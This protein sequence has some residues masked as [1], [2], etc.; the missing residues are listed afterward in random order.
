MDF[1]ISV[2]IMYYHFKL[3]AVVKARCKY[4]NARRRV[5]LFMEKEVELRLF[6]CTAF[7][8]R[9]F[10]LHIY[11]THPQLQGGM[12]P[13]HFHVSSLVSISLDSIKRIPRS[14]GNLNLIINTI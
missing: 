4:K 8:S 6:N 7:S 9:G 1:E 2:T 12:K 11:Y 5:S 14:E 13:R 10:Y 3:S